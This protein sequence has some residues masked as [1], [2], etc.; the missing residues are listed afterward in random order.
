MPRCSVKHLLLGTAALVLASAS[1]YADTLTQ[2]VQFGPSYTDYSNATGSPVAFQLFNSNLGILSSVSFASTYQFSGGM[3]LTNV[4]Q[5]YSSGSAR[6]QSAARFGSSDSG[7]AAVLDSKVNNTVDPTNGTAVSIGSTT[8]TPIAYD[9]R[10]K[11]MSYTLAP[12]ESTYLDASAGGSTPLITD[13]TASDLSAFFRP[14]GGV[15]SILLST[16]TGVIL[17]QSGG[18]AFG[19]PSTNAAAS[20]TVSYNYTAAPVAVTPEPSSFVLLGTGVLGMVGAA[21]RRLS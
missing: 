15:Y 11:T 19:S 1:A 8:L 18:N 16:L 5:S 9:L 17:S 3:M 4:S 21:R 14:G 20:L 10:S 2:T 12:G 7:I 6:V 13:T